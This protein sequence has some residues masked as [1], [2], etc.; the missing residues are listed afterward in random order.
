MIHFDPHMTEH[1]E[2]WKPD[3]RET[4]DDITHRVEMFL[5]W[6]VRQAANNVVVVSHGV[7]LEHLF[8]LKA[9]EGLERGHRRVHNLD[10]FSC[11]C[12]SRDGH[13]VRLESWRQI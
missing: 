10:A 5:A 12:V 4:W 2:R 9:P 6:I 3:Q 1:D 13:F 11:R 8:R 7:F